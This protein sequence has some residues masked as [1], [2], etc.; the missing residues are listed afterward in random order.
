M[1]ISRALFLIALLLPLTLIYLTQLYKLARMSSIAA[2]MPSTIASVGRSYVGMRL[3]QA[4][5][6][7][8][9]PMH[10]VV[11]VEANS[12]FHHR[13]MHCVMGRNAQVAGRLLVCMIGA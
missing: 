9:P 4:L 3:A 1:Y 11:V 13:K 2:T 6:P 8:L 12:H 7:V 10:R 5:V